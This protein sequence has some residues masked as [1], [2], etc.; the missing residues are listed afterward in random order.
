[1][2]MRYRCTNPTVNSYKFMTYRRIAEVLRISYNDVQ[3]LARQA[4][5]PRR[6]VTFEQRVR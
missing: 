1:M 2:L 6:P 4:L 5:K 3:Y